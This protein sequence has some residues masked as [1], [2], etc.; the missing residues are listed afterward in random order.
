MSILIIG[1][2]H[3]KTGNEKQTNILMS[4][5]SEIMTKNDIAFV[6]ILGDTLDNHGKIDLECLCRAADF[7]EMI[8]S[9]G[10]HLFVLI[11]N[12]DRKNNKDFMTNKH[13]FRGWRNQNGITIVES[14]Y[15]YDFPVSN[16]GI[17]TDQ[18]MKF[19]FVPYV[20]NDRYIEALRVGNVN[21]DEISMFFSHQ[22][23][24]GC[25]INKLTG[26]KCDS[27]DLN[28]PLNISGHI[29]DFED[30]QPN[31]K[32]VGTPFQHNFSDS[33]NKGVFL[34][35]L[36]NALL[37][38]TGWSLIKKELNIPKKIVW[39][40]HY[41]DLANVVLDP[42][43]DIRLE[44]YGPTAL[45]REI[46]KRPDMSLKF[47][48]ISKKYKEETKDEKPKTGTIKKTKGDFYFFN[49]YIEKISKDPRMFGVHMSL[50]PQ[51]NLQEIQ[52]QA[53]ILNTV[54]TNTI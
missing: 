9:T 19:C 53:Q 46:M 43:L 39:R 29:H 10:K 40:V 25:K 35:D 36:K 31:L 22:E 28:W 13:P 37:N 1:D 27:W 16:L 54:V 5:I 8:I 15:V 11:G 24:A 52:R 20:P 7:F 14:T 49:A 2:I 45:V 30:V 18:K 12:H 6:V 4:D 21:I 42:N 32:Y 26:G 17:E 50:Y 3:F 44:I 23:F 38:N 33:S 47:Q 41:K 51:T 34:L 48:N